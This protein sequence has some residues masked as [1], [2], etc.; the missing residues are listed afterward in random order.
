MDLRSSFEAYLLIGVIIQLL[1]NAV[2]GTIPKIAHVV[3]GAIIWPW[4]L[5]RGAKAI[6]ESKQ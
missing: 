4:L 1:V 5:Y 2:N 3:I 6:H